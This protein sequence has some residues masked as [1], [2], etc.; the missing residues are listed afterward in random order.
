[1]SLE[2]CTLSQNVNVWLKKGL[3]IQHAANHLSEF[4]ISNF[5]GGA[6]PNPPVRLFCSATCHTC[7]TSRIPFS[8]LLSL[9]HTSINFSN[10]NPVES[11][12][13]ASYP[14]AQVLELTCRNILQKWP[15]KQLRVNQKNRKILWLQT[16]ESLS[17]AFDFK[18][19]IS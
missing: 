15:S 13:K 17:L 16:L 7:Y 6:Y 19:F 2:P 12:K 11:S 14:H 9:D 4:Q 3:Q 1:M 8:C 10:H 18:Y 5:S